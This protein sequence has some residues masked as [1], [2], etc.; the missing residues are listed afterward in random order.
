MQRCTGGFMVVSYRPGT[1]ESPCYMTQSSTL[2][3]VGS[4]TYTFFLLSFVVRS[5]L[6]SF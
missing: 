3:F 1:G 4:M 6:M 5:K 2:P